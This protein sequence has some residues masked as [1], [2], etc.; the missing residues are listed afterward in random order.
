MPRYTAK[1]SDGRTVTLEADSQPSEDD[2]LKAVAD[3]KTPEPPPPAPEPPKPVEAPFKLP[4]QVAN[5]YEAQAAS[6][7]AG[8]ENPSA[9]KPFVPIPRP[10]QRGFTIGREGI[11]MN[12]ESIPHALLREGA[13]QLISIPEF[14]E[15]PK[16]I[17]S[18]LAAPAAP[19]ATAT[20]F[21]GLSAKGVYE[22]AQQE[23]EDWDKK[24][25][26]EKA[27]SILRT[28]AGGAMTY[29][30][31]KGA[32][33]MGIRGAARI[34]PKAAQEASKDLEAPGRPSEGQKA[35]VVP[36]AAESAL[37]EEEARYLR[38]E[39]EGM[40]TPVD[41]VPEPAQQEGL[42]FARRRL[43]GQFMGINRQTG[44]IEV[45]PEEFSKWLKSV[46]ENRRSKAVR[47]RLGEEEIHLKTSD[48]DATTYWGRLSA[49]E[50]AIAERIYTGKWGGRKFYPGL[51]E[52]DLA[53]EAIR[54]RMQRLARMDLSESAEAALKERWSVQSLD[55]LSNTI[56]AIREGMTKATPEQKAMMDRMLQN[57]GGAQAA[58]ASGQTPARSKTPK[59]IASMSPQE[60]VDWKK[61]TAYGPD[62]PAQLAQSLSA[63]DLP[64][65]E[66]ERDR[67][68]K[69]V[70]SDLATATPETADKIWAQTGPK[71][72]KAQTLNEII[73]AKKAEPAAIRKGAGKEEPGFFLP[74]VP[75]G[76]EVER[77]LNLQRT[78]EGT[79]LKIWPIELDWNQPGKEGA[80]RPISDAEAAASPKELG[81]ILTSDARIGGSQLPVSSSRRL[82]VLLDRKNGEVHIVSTYPHGRSGALAVNPAK[83]GEAKPNV[84]LADLL[85][86]YKPIYSILR[87]SPIKN[88]HQR[89][90]N[91]DA[92]QQQFGEEA[93]QRS[94]ESLG[95]QAIAHQAGEP[96]TPPQYPGGLEEEGPQDS[97]LKAFHDFFEGEVP[98]TKNDFD[99]LIGNAAATATRQMVNAVH[100]AY[101]EESR[102]NP[103]ASPEE[104][105]EGALSKLYEDLKKSDTRTQFIDSAQR[106]LRQGM[107]PTVQKGEVA[108][109]EK[110]AYETGGPAAINKQLAEDL[111]AIGESFR[112]GVANRESRDLIAR[113]FD[114]SANAPNNIARRI[115][116]GIRIQ[117]AGYKGALGKLQ[118]LAGE[119]PGNPQVLSAANAVV[120]SGFDKSKIPDFQSQVAKGKAEAQ[121]LLNSSSWRDR[122]IGRV[123]DRNQ[124]QLK[125]ELD[126]AEAHWDDPELKSTASRMAIQLENMRR[127]LKNNGIKVKRAENYLPGRY[128]MSAWNGTHAFFKMPKVWGTKWRQPKVFKDYY[129]A[130]SVGPYVAATRDGA[131]LVGHA[132]R[133]A[134]EMISRQK[135]QDTLKQMNGPTG[136]PIA[137]DSKFSQ[138]RFTP[139]KEGYVDIDMGGKHLSV[140]EDFAPI[141]RQLTGRSVIEDWAPS[142][143]A[144]HFE[145]LLKHNL[146]L[147]DFFHFGR[148]AYYAA[149][150]MGRAAGWRKGW[151]SIDIDPRDV[152]EAVN[153]GVITQKEADWANTPV[154]FKGSTITRRELLHEFEKGGFNIGQIQDA[155]YKDL[156]TKGTPVS[157]PVAKTWSA[158]TDPTTGRYNRFLFDRF[159]R[160]LMAESA[161]KEFERQSAKLGPGADH[162]K[163]VRDISRDLN[164]YYGNLGRQGIFKAKWQQ[165]L[166]RLFFL[167]PQWVEGLVNKELVGYSRLSGLSKLTG[168]RRGLTTLGTTGTAMGKGLAAMFVLTQGL[169]L[170]T[171]G[172][173][174]WDN[175]EKG[176]KFD[177]WIPSGG[178]REE[179]MW[180]SPMA[181]F[182][183]LTHDIYRLSETKPTVADAVSQIAGNKQS[184]ILRALMIAK[185]GQL[186]TG[187][188]ATTSA[189]RLEGAAGALLPVPISFGKGL[190]SIGHA[191]AP[192]LVAPTPPGQLQ[193]QLASSI[194]LKFEPQM[195]VVSEVGNMAKDFLVKEGLKSE[196]GW[197][198]EMTDEPGYS[199]LRQALREGN[200]REARKNL[201]ALRK[202]RTD[203]QI[204]KAMKNWSVKPFTGTKKEERMFLDSLSDPE[205]A[206]YD[207]AQDRRQREYEAFLDWYMRQP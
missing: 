179:G 32:L 119:I 122:R 73:D 6:L 203:K 202:T 184:P 206:K 40:S 60:V 114:A 41:V 196:T 174:T 154:K 18:T 156:Y 56:R 25:P 120:Q 62:T 74:D 118:K 8:M 34:L 128:D 97:E 194:G 138:G 197:R 69:E 134:M 48:Q 181:V 11:Q 68:R 96:S 116:N 39:Q 19:A 178:G 36:K 146:L 171:R 166:A 172:K 20:T 93:L 143:I 9:D 160:G 149:S 88:F 91:L 102:L 147:G 31:G 190:R 16:G 52:L 159:S 144:L 84:P 123:W 186:S 204:L 109:P 189:G 30:L 129:Q 28:T 70:E 58:L 193:R 4:F 126:Y 115:E 51:G 113:S 95:P 24:T 77:S 187:E 85:D 150:I 108:P 139:G 92:Y 12:P 43:A 78:G 130:S 87:D 101:L 191:V 10:F 121:R 61:A 26:A 66:S 200:E 76:A 124:D 13:N 105:V 199:K 175:E 44:R 98:E 99:R 140:H 165:D 103:G 142:R 188:M 23:A 79:G 89:F 42:P 132:A 161:V 153:R 207:Q 198:Q 37:S 2:I 205:L 110:Y 104:N 182:N 148:M 141:V 155:L 81:K 106:R 47:S 173:P 164:N 50:K 35:V 64:A 107:A 192:N 27:A 145:Q 14:L 162:E 22:T 151:T 59:D 65:L 72:L 57:V 54:M 82:T 83:S 21:A 63:D 1:L 100:K 5:P 80:Y 112:L 195:S 169:N 131:S 3:Y 163:L 45:Y 185:T 158:I 127:A 183:E 75:K 86:R 135:W 33:E 157:G 53:H 49:A 125:A 152:K 55:T 15:T 111:S 180:L 177:A 94:Q 17:L 176:H 117:S 168:Q 38:A 46:P 201:E 136:D 133:K 167:A 7:A 67:L 90:E 29:F 170:I 137:V 71:S